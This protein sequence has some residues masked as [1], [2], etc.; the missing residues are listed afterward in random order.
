MEI[1]PI[2]EAKIKT[3]SISFKDNRHFSFIIED[4]PESI[5]LVKNMITMINYYSKDL[6]EVE[7]K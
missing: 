6:M 4:R 2:T 1:K 7:I 3:V 5:N